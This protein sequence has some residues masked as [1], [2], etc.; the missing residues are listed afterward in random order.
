M[1]NINSQSPI[2]INELEEKLS[3]YLA[4]LFSA[5]TVFTDWNQSKNL[6]NIT[7]ADHLIWSDMT[8]WRS[9]D[10]KNW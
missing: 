6:R 3:N 2:W 9:Y 8:V 1:I 10:K 5:K 7:L 4:N